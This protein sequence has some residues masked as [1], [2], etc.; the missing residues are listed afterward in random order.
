MTE[1]ILWVAIIGGTMAQAS[2]SQQAM[3]FKTETLCEAA[4]TKLLAAFA[5]RGVSVV[6]SCVAYIEVP[7]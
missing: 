7:K 1:F 4:K 2:S 5:V 3:P 6:G